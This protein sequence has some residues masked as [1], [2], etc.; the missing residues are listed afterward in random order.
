MKQLLWNHDSSILCV[1]CD[2]SDSN[3]LLF[4]SCT[5][6]AW[7]IKKWMTIENKIITAKWLLDNSLRLITNN[8]NYYTLYW[9]ETLCTSSPGT[10]D[11]VAVIDYCENNIFFSFNYW[12]FLFSIYFFR[13]SF[14]NTI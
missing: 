4:L 8:G 12:N 6:Y 14:T 7:Q 5:N 10:Q 1:Q 2:D 11:W 13:F 3:Y 9:S